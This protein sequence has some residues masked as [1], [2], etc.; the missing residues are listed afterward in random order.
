[1]ASVS[2]HSP[3][4]P[5]TEGSMGTS[6]AATPNVCK[7][8]GPPAPFVPSPLPNMGKSGMSPKGYS[9]KVTIEGNK[10]AIFGAT[11]ESMGDM[12]SKATGGGLLS[13]NTHGPTK[14]ITPGS[15]FVSI[16]GKSVHLLGEPMLNNCGP[17]GAPPNTGAT[18]PGVDQSESKA[19][20]INLECGEVGTYSELNKKAA[21]P[22]DM[23]RDHIPSKAA[24]FER[25]KQ[26]KSDMTTDE[27]KCV[28]GK[29]EGRG[30]AIA[31]PRSAHRGFSPTC[32][33]KNDDAQIRGDGKSPESMK[34]AAERDT[35]AMQE[36]MDKDHKECAKAYEEAAKKVKEHDTEKMCEEAIAECT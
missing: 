12:P 36:H 35:K 34:A 7:M 11:F 3:K 23:E 25:A 9:K 1:M 13:M 26:I 22:V 33:S 28:K 14:F 30:M 20:K 10:V 15:L 17:T 18:L 2:I 31:I 21:K 16:E 5:V 4:T 8:P 24:L 27:F 19:K 6:K 32:G 29:L